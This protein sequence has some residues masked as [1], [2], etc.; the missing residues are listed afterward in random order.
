MSI[1]WHHL[2]IL[3]TEPS[4]SVEYSITFFFQWKSFPNLSYN[5]NALLNILSHLFWGLLFLF[6][7]YIIHMCVCMMVGACECSCPR[8]PEA[9][10]RSSCTLDLQLHVF[11]TGLIWVLGQSMLLITEASHWP[12]SSFYTHL[13]ITHLREI[14]R[15]KNI[16]Y[17]NTLMFGF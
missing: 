8:K 10:R 16:I 12:F 15:Y 13:W 2:V 1:F 6:I 14:L 7:V 11:F 5:I 3:Q 17:T 9:H 4:L